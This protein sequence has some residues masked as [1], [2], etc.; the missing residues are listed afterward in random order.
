[1]RR[2]TSDLQGAGSRLSILSRSASEGIASRT[3]SPAELAYTQD[4]SWNEESFIED[5]GMPIN[6]RDQ[7]VAI[8]PE[9]EAQLDGNGSDSDSSLDLHTPLP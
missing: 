6:R 1:M 9:L 4:E 2:Y 8:D 7:F 3:E 5:Y